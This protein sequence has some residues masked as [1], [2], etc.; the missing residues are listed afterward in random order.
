M[1]KENIYIIYKENL[2]ER[3]QNIPQPPK[4]LYV[5]GT[6]PKP[7][8]KI[9]C[10]VGARR[11]SS[12]GEEAC[13]KLISGLKGYD[14]CIVSGLALGIDS[15]AHRSALDAGLSTIAFPGSGL[16]DKVL[17]PHKNKR[18]AEEIICADGAVISEFEMWQT[19]T[20]WTFPQRNR[21]M[22][23]I[24]QA[25]IVIEAKMKSGT[26]IT[27]RL[28][29]D[30]NRDVGAVPGQITSELS[31]GPNDLIRDG[32][33]P[34]TCSDDILE[35]LGLKTKDEIE[36]EK[37]QAGTRKDIQPSLLLNLTATERMIVEYLQIEAHTNEKLVM[38][39]GLSARE[40][41]ESISSL[42]IQGL[43]TESGGRVRMV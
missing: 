1:N 20:D 42:E 30:Y 14:I 37:S 4:K 17:Y 18:L 28:A 5:A 41:N 11:H 15:I 8:T 2:P 32:A 12:Y 24:S 39:S 9:L 19:G 22:A 16:D 27:S 6:M 3:L 7:D 23:G 40:I 35:I 36:N 25:T 21:L 26:L 31:D 29:L 33:T 38:K 10:V 43:I 34:I 13:K